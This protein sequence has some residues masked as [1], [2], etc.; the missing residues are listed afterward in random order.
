MIMLFI[1]GVEYRDEI[2]E[3]KHMDQSGLAEEVELPV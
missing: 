2:I 3:Y 1:Y